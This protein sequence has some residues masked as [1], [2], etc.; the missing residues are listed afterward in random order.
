MGSF[1]AQ[2]NQPQR[3]GGG[4]VLAAWVQ[5]RAAVYMAVGVGI[6][7]GR[8]EAGRTDDG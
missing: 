8:A 5:V 4:G 3:G 1:V 2:P 6:C 7:L